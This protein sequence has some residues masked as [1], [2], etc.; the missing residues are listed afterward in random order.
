LPT[1]VKKR[2]QSETPLE[3]I[4]SANE[5]RYIEEEERAAKRIVEGNSNYKDILV[6]SSLE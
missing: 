1:S 5:A 6:K 4:A 2:K 3:E